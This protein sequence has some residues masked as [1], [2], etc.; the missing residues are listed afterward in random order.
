M[1]RNTL[2]ATLAA[3]AATFAV[4]PIAH[5]EEARPIMKTEHSAT[6]KPT[7]SG[8][9]AVNGLNYY[10]QVYGSRC[11]CFMADWA[12]SRCSAPI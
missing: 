2:I 6:A 12:R 3:V 1:S 11:C 9:A 5:A 7:K 4:L 10:Y 8:H